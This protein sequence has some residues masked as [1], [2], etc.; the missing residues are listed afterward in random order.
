MLTVVCMETL[1]NFTC[2]GME[3]NM[4]SVDPYI[5]VVLN[6]LGFIA[7]SSRTY[8]DRL[9]KEEFERRLLG[10]QDGV[11]SELKECIYDSPPYITKDQYGFCYNNSCNSDKVLKLYIQS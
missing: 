11:I 8:I 9:E 5:K 4:Y 2:C 10:I 1:F 7:T 3:I 6:T